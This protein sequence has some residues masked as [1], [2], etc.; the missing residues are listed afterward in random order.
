AVGQLTQQ[1]A[2]LQHT[3]AFPVNRWNN[4]R[5]DLSVGC[6]DCAAVPSRRCL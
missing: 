4:R 1:A 6:I 3:A 2:S 5:I